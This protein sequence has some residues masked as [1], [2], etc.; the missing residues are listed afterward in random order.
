MQLLGIGSRFFV[1]VTRL[2]PP[3]YVLRLTRMTP[4]PVS[5]HSNQQPS[6]DLNE[7]DFLDEC[8]CVAHIDH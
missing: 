7:E 3:S 4:A 1:S 8:K 2:V 6:K 5:G